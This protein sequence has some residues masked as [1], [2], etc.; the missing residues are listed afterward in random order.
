MADL[1]QPTVRARRSGPTLVVASLAPDA[2]S[3]SGPTSVDN[4][5]AYARLVGSSRQASYRRLYTTTRDVTRSAKGPGARG[6]RPPVDLCPL[7]APPGAAA[8]ARGRKTKRTRE[9]SPGQWIGSLAAASI[10][11]GP[12]PDVTM[13]IRR[14]GDKVEARASCRSLPSS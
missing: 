14:D 7:A 10:G 9:S 8:P 11:C 5:P 3:R 13:R 6:A 2:A 1:P 4:R 12:R